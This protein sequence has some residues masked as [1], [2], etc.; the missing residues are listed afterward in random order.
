MRWFCLILFSIAT[1]TQC[2]KPNAPD[3]IQPNGDVMDFPVNFSSE[4]SEITIYDDVKVILRNEEEGTSSFLRCNEF[5][6][7][8]IELSEDENS[9][10]IRNNN[11]C[12]W[13]RKQP[14]IELYIYSNHIKNVTNHG[15]K[16]LKTETYQTQILQL[17]QWESL[18]T[19][20]LDVSTDTLVVNMHTLNGTAVVSGSASHASFYTNGMT[21][22]LDNG[23]TCQTAF[24]NNSGSRDIYISAQEYLNAYLAG[25]GNIYYNTP[26]LV[27]NL[28]LLGEGDIIFANF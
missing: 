21:E 25:R 3:C 14:L 10:T 8:D 17:E 27:I 13:V 16:G 19:N 22:I 26:D 2:K 9:L 15:T 12:N 28:N 20:E 11:T 4:I 7:S 6:E 18:A 23:F 1:L 5:L 24:V